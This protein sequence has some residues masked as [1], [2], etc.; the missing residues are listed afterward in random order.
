M[1]DEKE[2]VLF[3]GD[4]GAIYNYCPALNDGD[5]KSNYSNNTFDYNTADHDGGAVKWNGI[6]P[7]NL[8]TNNTFGNNNTAVYGNNYASMAI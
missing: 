6:E 1:D 8:T 5:C 4:G 3:Y 2:L 7:Y